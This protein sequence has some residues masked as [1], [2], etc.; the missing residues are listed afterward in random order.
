MLAP[1]FIPGERTLEAQKVLRR[2]SDCI[3][4]RLWR[5]ELRNVLA[6][7]MRTGKASLQTALEAINEAEK[8]M[9]DSEFESSS[10]A[11]LY[12]AN[13]SGATA[14]DCEFVALAQAFDI[15]LL[16]YDRRLIK[17]FPET[18]IPVRDWLAI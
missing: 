14:Y 17:A 11:V 15:P 12:L 1:L 9:V 5:S 6:T 4:P 13:Q 8:L 16:T 10:E 3:A 18:A 2:D 7:H